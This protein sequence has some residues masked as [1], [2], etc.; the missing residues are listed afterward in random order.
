MKHNSIICVDAGPVIQLVAFPDNT[1]I[2][3]IWDAWDREKQKIVAPTLLYYEV[4]N[5]LYRY[6]SQCLLR[7]ETV[8][9]AL[10]AVLSLPIELVGDADLHLHAKELAV[11]YHLPAA[12]DAHYMALTERLGGELWTTDK[13]LENILRPMGIESLKC[14]RVD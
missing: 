12:Y 8:S 5:V 7:Q 3:D 10:L 9:T 2:Q 1:L 14:L 11:K 4:T 13:R 6:Q